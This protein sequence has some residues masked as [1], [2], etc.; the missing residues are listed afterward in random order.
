[1]NLPDRAQWQRLSPLLD[2]LLE[3]DDAA[4]AAR[5]AGLR[6]GD[7]ATADALESFLADAQAAGHARFLTGAAP[8]PFSFDDATLAG[9]SIGAYVLEQPLGQGG[10]GSVW[11]ARR[12]DG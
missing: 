11:R 12:A 8:R 1:M 10:S 9:Q 7:P 4:R 2:E 5:L 6:A 3:L